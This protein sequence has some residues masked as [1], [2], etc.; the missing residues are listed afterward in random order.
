MKA[1][2]VVKGGTIVTPD[3]TVHGGVAIADGKIVA[4]GADDTLPEGKRVIDAAGLYVL[5]GLIDAHVHFRD[6]GLTHKEDFA[7]GSTAAVCGGIT[8][9]V[10]M[11]NQ[12]PP[13]DSAEQILVKK[14]IAESKS[15]CDFAILGVVH[16]TNADEIPPMAKAGAIGYKIF[17]GETI[18]NLP[19]PDDGMCQEA[20]A[21]I[22]TSGIPL[23]VHA[24]NRQIQHYWTNR[25]KAEGKNDPIYWE[26]SRPALCEASSIA[27]IMF[28]AE[29]FGTML[30]VVH[31][32]TRQAVEMVRSAKARGLRFTAETGPHYLLRTDRDLA[33]SGPLLKMNPP[34]R[35]KEHQDALWAGLLDGAVDM[36]ATD[37][38]PHTLEE[39]G[40]DINGR[41]TKTAIW[42]CIS[43]F[44][45][46]E[47]NVPLMLTEVNK[48]R[49][50][51]NHY[52]R[53]QSENVA[54]VW[55][56]Y[57]RKGAI[58]LGSDGDLTIVDMNREA[59]IEPQ[60][61]HS[62]NVPTPWASWKVKGLPVY[63]VVRGNI[64]A[65]DGEPVGGVVG[66]MQTPV[67]P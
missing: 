41:M 56:I 3:A 1:D 39:K 54:K 53:V 49:M 51:L 67:R 2:L 27:H 36:I 23:C 33:V 26:A 24:E 42:D 44:C 60:K 43:G 45:G 19:F 25:L 6:P 55:Q 61:L 62:K 20:F 52:A 66:R 50:T 48:G 29:N 15:L 13:T 5:P 22:A 59:T 8:T 17:F 35:G 7:S 37:H 32:S 64:Q 38:S 16:Q 40:C 28:L 57:P 31:A 63:T 12:I 34:V 65:K 21:N 14:Q 30:H 9:V 10:D 46:V 11:P 58:R 4:I 47:T 18:G